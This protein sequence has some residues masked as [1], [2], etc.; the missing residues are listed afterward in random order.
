MFIGLNFNIFSSEAAPEALGKHNLYVAYQDFLDYRSTHSEAYAPTLHSAIA[1]AYELGCERYEHKLAFEMLNSAETLDPNAL[2]EADQKAILCI[3]A[4]APAAKVAFVLENS[5]TK[6][7]LINMIYEIFPAETRFF[8]AAKRAD[9]KAVEVRRQAAIELFEMMNNASESLSLKRFSAQVASAARD[10]NKSFLNDDQLEVAR[11]ILTTAVCDEQLSFDQRLAFASDLMWAPNANGD[12]MLGTE[13][14]KLSLLNVVFSFAAREDLSVHQRFKAGEMVIS[15]Y[16]GMFDTQRPAVTEIVESLIDCSQRPV[17]SSFLMTTQK[18]YADNPSNAEG[19]LLKSEQIKKIHNHFQRILYDGRGYQKVRLLNHVARDAIISLEVKRNVVEQSLAIMGEILTPHENF[20]A[21]E[22]IISAYHSPENKYSS[23]ATDE[24]G[25]LVI[26]KLRVLMKS[27]DLHIQVRTYI[28]EH[29]LTWLRNSR[30]NALPEAVN[31]AVEYGI[32]LLYSA[33]TT[34]RDKSWIAKVIFKAND[35]MFTTQQFNVLFPNLVS[36]L[37]KEEDD[38]LKRDLANKLLSSSHVTPQQCQ[39]VLQIFIDAMNDPEKSMET[40]NVRAEFVKSSPQATAEQKTAAA[41]IIT[42]FQAATKQ[43]IPVIT[44]TDLLLQAMRTGDVLPY[45]NYCRND[46]KNRTISFLRQNKADIAINSLPGRTMD[47]YVEE[48]NK[49]VAAAPFTFQV[50]MPESY[51]LKDL[52]RTHLR[53]DQK[54]EELTFAQLRII[55]SEWC[56]TE[57]DT[58]QGNSSDEEIPLGEGEEVGVIFKV[59]VPQDAFAGTDTEILLQ[60]IQTGN[61]QPYVKLCKDDAKMKVARFL[62]QIAPGDDQIGFIDPAVFYCQ[63]PARTKGAFKSALNERIDT[64][65]VGLPTSCRM[66]D[67]MSSYTKIRT[68]MWEAVNYFMKQ[69]LSS[70]V[71]QNVIDQNALRLANI[72]HDVCTRDGLIDALAKIYN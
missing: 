37:Y 53:L 27:S 5:A 52:L 58:N 30:V 10:D 41:A 44:D 11:K 38:Y 15:S 14:Q 70:G 42:A 19:S 66:Q 63:L 13:E 12:R 67:L 43:H 21:S 8:D 50:A 22:G 33:E 23:V 31:E 32:T 51:K 3:L 45:V 18:N 55:D 4:W 61:M 1:F 56:V 24:D 34:E 26:Q 35:H 47:Q 40:R 59:F 46:V 2:S 72:D 60:A 71:S 69:S 17:F 49:R 62:D 20:L 25:Y 9:S 7:W 68:R 64:V 16:C 48:I 39:E 65:Q 54:L 36:A 28:I 6:P 57:E 29:I